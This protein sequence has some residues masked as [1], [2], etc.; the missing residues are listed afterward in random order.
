T[1]PPRVDAAAAPDRGRAAHRGDG[2]ERGRLRG[3]VALVA[4][5]RPRRRDARTAWVAGARLRAAQAGQ[6][7]G[8]AVTSMHEGMTGMVGQQRMQRPL[9]QPTPETQEFWDGLKRHE[10][11]TQHCNTCDRGYFYPRPFCPYPDCHS[12]DV[13]WRTASGKGTLHS[14]VIAHR[15]HPAFEP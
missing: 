7:A 8:A 9:P 14:Y 2:R 12:Q 4:S 5:W 13:E 11:R 1:A 3:A 10:L 6:P 15:R